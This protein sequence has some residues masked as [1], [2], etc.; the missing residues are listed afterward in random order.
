MKPLIIPK[1]DA[2]DTLRF[3]SKI[4]K[5]SSDSCWEWMAYKTN[6]GYGQFGIK[7]KIYLAHRVSWAIKHCIDPLSKFVCHRCDNPS[8]VN[9]KHLFLGT[10]SDNMADMIKKGRS[11]HTK[12]LRGQDCPTSKLTNSDVSEIW[13]LHLKEGLGERKLGAKFSVTPAN[14]H[15][16]LSGKTW[17]HLIPVN[18]IP[19]ILPKNGR[20]RKVTDNGS[21]YHEWQLALLRIKEL[22]G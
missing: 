1:L 3:W 6:S 5:T 9:P 13:R 10:Q 2:K 7:Y 4:N 15:A 22:G 11:D 20:P 12:N 14:I 8:C 21:H 16:I 19:S 17:K 18:T